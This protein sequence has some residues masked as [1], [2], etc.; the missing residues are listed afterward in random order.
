MNWLKKYSN[1]IL[2]WIADCYEDNQCS[3]K[4]CEYK[5]VCD[6]VWKNIKQIEREK[7]KQLEVKNEIL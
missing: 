4:D 3:S 1:V 6:E 7:Q 5:A 2:Y